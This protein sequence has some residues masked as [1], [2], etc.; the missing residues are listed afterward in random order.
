[1][2]LKS[3]LIKYFTVLIKSTVFGTGHYSTYETAVSQGGVWLKLCII[4]ELTNR[5]EVLTKLSVLYGASTL[6]IS[7]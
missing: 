6:I 5:G 3:L 2:F 1:M 7:V 4:G